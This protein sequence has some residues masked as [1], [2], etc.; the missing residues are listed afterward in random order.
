MIKTIIAT[1]LIVLTIYKI[2]R[3]KKLNNKKYY[4]SFFPKFYIS[5]RDSDFVNIIKNIEGENFKLKKEV[6]DILI[7]KRGFF[8]GDFSS[9]IAP[10]TVKINKSENNIYISYTTFV[11]FDT[12][13]LSREFKKILNEM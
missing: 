12:G 11:L 4:L 8:L 6:D 5:F 1:I 10:I 9:K 3:Y 13:D 2:A 7:Y